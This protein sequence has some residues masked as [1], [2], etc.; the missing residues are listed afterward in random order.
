MTQIMKTEGFDFCP[1][2]QV[3]KTPLHPLP[4]TR[5]ACFRRKNSTLTNHGR[6]PPQLV[7]DFGSIGT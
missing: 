2:E 6:K 4:S 7:G 3:L 1:F 5:C